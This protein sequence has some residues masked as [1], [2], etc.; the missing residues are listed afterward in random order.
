[1]LEEIGSMRYFWIGAI[2]ARTNVCDDW[3]HGLKGREL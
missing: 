2:K 1:V 3:R